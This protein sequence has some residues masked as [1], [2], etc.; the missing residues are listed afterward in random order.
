MIDLTSGQK[1]LKAASST[2]AAA[3]VSAAES[4]REMAWL[5]LIDDSAAD[6]WGG[7]GAATASF[8]ARTSRAAGVVE[9]E[10]ALRQK[11]EG[12]GQTEKELQKGFVHLMQARTRALPSAA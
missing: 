8:R 12:N 6:A 11:R 5:P 1:L 4:S 7:G 3:A 10:I 2:S 9:R